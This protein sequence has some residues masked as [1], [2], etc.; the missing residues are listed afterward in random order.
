M[1]KIKDILFIYLLLIIEVLIIFKSKYIYISVVNSSKIFMFKIFPFMFPSMIIG[2]MLTNVNLSKVMPVFINKIFNKLFNFNNIHTTL[3][4]TSILTG[5]PSNALFINEALENNQIDENEAESLLCITNYINPVF[6][7]GSIGIGIFNSTKIGILLVLLLVLSNFIKAY[8]LKKNFKNNNI[9]YKYKDI[10]IIDIIF[11]SIKK[12]INSSI[13]I[14]GIIIMFNILI[15][16]LD[17]IFNLPAN[18]NFI[19]NASIEITSGIQKISNLN[20]SYLS[21]FLLSYYFINFSGL[22]IHMQVFSIF[23]NKKIR[24]LKYLIFRLI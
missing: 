21:K 17:N 24:Y 6:I 2:N 16:L 13:M 10:K 14:F 8:I 12:S 19:L 3:F 11:K 20:T 18:I 9:K 1:R 4:L 22:C 23:Q 7:I 5:S 15:V